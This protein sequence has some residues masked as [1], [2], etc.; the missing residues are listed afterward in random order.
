M[1][2][3]TRTTWK[4]HLGNQ[5]IDP[6]RI[7]TPK[8][9]DDVV[10]IVRLAEEMGVTVRAVGSGHS[11]SDAALTEGFLLRPEGMARVPAAEPDFIRPEWA[12]RKLG[13]VEAG[14]RV[15]EVNAYLDAHDLGLLNMGGYDGQTVAGV[16][17]TATHG[18][19]ITFGSLSDF[20]H[21]MDVVTAGG[22]VQRFE[23]RDGPTDPAA[24]A[25][26]HGDRRTLVQDDHVFDAVAVGIGCLGIICT[27]MI[28]VRER[29]FLREVRELHPWSKVRADLE[30]G[31]VLRDN[32]HY[33]L[34][35]SPYAPDGEQHFLVTTRNIVDDPR[36]RPWDK[37]MRNWLVEAAAAF[38]LTPNIINLLL[39][40]RPSLAPRLLEGSMKALVKDEYDAISHKVFNIGL[41]NY[42]P[43]YS[44]EVAVAV[45][46]RH[47]E[48]IERIIA[49]ADERRRIGRV[50]QSSPIALR[51]VKASTAY[52]SMMHGQDTMMIELIGLKGNDGGY[53]LLHAYME[54]LYELGGRP[55][56]GQVNTLTGSHGFVESMY[57][58]YADWIDVRARLDPDGVFDSPFTKRVGLSADAFAP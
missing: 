16:I 53:E 54:A 17:S 58:R 39:D 56:W 33:E 49:V 29:Y 14:A 40:V 35:F 24:Y 5:R 57:P 2:F 7:Y 36:A 26:Q 10:E 46:G 20:V 9:I 43:G 37:R 50:Y 18:S 8:S 52:L 15:R 47:I 27:V 28:E 1:E 55:H 30:D 11:W 44:A 4:N 12:Q 45:D 22:A 38:P 23:R 19:G 34:I 13:R 31:G 51:F 3:Q 21:S 42:L 6:L 32:R 41:A 48:A 25:A